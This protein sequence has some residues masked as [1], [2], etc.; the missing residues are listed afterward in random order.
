MTAPDFYS[1]LRALRL[2][3]VLDASVEIITER[4]WDALSMTEVAKRSGVPRQSLYKE[5][6]T[7]TELGR[8]VVDREVGRFLE[9]V[10]SGF[11]EHPDS[12]EDGIS[13]A[14]RGV[15]EHGRSNAALAAVLRPGHDSGLLAMVTV[16]PDAVLGQASAAVGALVGDRASEA[17]VDCVVRLTLSHLVQPT[18][19]VDEA[20]DRIDRVV[21]SFE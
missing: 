20:V 12:F 8:A 19:D 5:V 9:Q 7:R 14:V 3:R 1:E 4:G 13:A 2:E 16:N 10:S 17:L 6:G 18:V 21:R 15:L 11:A